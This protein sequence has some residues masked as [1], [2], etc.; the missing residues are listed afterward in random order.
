MK[1]QEK[2]SREAMNLYSIFR[3]AGSPE[4]LESFCIQ[5]MKERQKDF[6][7]EDA[8]LVWSVAKRIWEKDN[9]GKNAANY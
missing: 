3:D 5:E 4:G 8:K 7:D 9:G 6:A 2:F 1:Y